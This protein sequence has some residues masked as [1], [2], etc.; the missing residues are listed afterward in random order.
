M[1]LENDVLEINDFGPSLDKVLSDYLKNSFKNATKGYL[2]SM[3]TDCAGYK[4]N[5]I[6]TFRSFPSCR[7][8]KAADASPFKCP[9][10]GMDACLRDSFAIPGIRPT[11]E[12]SVCSGFGKCNEKAGFICECRPTT[13]DG[14][15]FPMQYV[16]D[17]SASS[18]YC[19]SR[20]LDASSEGMYFAR[21]D[22][23]DEL[24]TLS[25]SPSFI[26]PAIICAAVV[27]SALYSSFWLRQNMDHNMVRA[28]Q[29]QF[30]HLMNL[31]CAVAGFSL[32]PLGFN[33]RTTFSCFTQVALQA[34]G[35]MMIVAPLVLKTVIIAAL[36]NN[37]S[38]KRKKD[39]RPIAWMATLGL[40][41]AELAIVCVLQGIAPLRPTLLLLD[42]TIEDW[43]YAVTCRAQTESGSPLGIAWGMALASVNVIM[44][45]WG[46][47]SSIQVRNVPDSFAEAKWIGFVIYNITF[48]TIV[49][50]PIMLSLKSNPEVMSIINCLTTGVVALAAVWIMHI[51]KRIL[52]RT[53]EKS[54]NPLR[55]HSHSTA[56]TSTAVELPEKSQRFR[57]TSQVARNLAGAAHHEKIRAGLQSK[58]S[59]RS[60]SSLSMAK[61]S[62]SNRNV[63]AKS[64]AIDF[65]GNDD[66]YNVG[67]HI[68]IK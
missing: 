31:G 18:G 29:P 65:S 62:G 10:E 57:T 25:G 2:S 13:I 22:S 51:P 49:C 41:F 59:P 9:R 7:I 61:P 52:V 66:D 67:T 33:E 55:S 19:F 35:F 11:S 32:I 39:Q 24:R 1:F 38:M 54:A 46:V 8:V 4:R 58:L 12:C 20:E 3:K 15:I 43:G 45:V 42:S 17:K 14:F 30:Q 50:T 5:Y 56:P 36:F 26:V 37:K 6:E 34:T 60:G 16:V 21:G 64:I 40:I 47:F 48:V 28:S 68:S 53:N 44:I 23:C 27:I 63:S